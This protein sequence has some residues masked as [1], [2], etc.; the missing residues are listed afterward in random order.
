MHPNFQIPSTK[1][2]ISTA[3]SVAATAMLVRSF[4]KDFVPPELRQ[5][6]F[7]KFHYFVATFTNEI[8]LVIDEYEG[9]NKNQLFYAA[10]IYLGTIS[11]P[12]TRRFRASLP[13][14]G[15]ENPCFYGKK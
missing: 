8:T 1:T 6:I 3:A 2:V 13:E 4:T 10:E 11:N 5:Y 9:L 12:S 7:T 14:K 15:E